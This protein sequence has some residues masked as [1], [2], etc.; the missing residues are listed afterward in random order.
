MRRVSN[1]PTNFV[2]QLILFALLVLEM[3]TS[4]IFMMWKFILLGREEL[5]FVVP[6]KLA[7]W[8][9]LQKLGAQKMDVLPDSSSHL[10]LPCPVCVLWASLYKVVW[11]NFVQKLHLSCF[12]RQIVV[13]AH[14]IYD[15]LHI[16]P[17]IHKKACPLLHF[18]GNMLYILRS[19]LI[20]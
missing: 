9:I 5:L 12:C 19:F 15:F 20:F 6:W 13:A 14:E 3:K 18:T 4:S 11:P 8:S 2:V 17:S 7:K 16:P 1:I 10:S